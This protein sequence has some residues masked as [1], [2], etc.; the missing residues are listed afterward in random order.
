MSDQK[1]S[2]FQSSRFEFRDITLDVRTGRVQR[3][4]ERLALEPRAYDLLVCLVHHAGEVMSRQ[5]LLDAIWKDVHVAPHSLTQAVLQLRHA[6]NDDTS[7]PQFIETVHRRGYRFVAP[8]RPPDSIRDSPDRPSV[9]PA[10]IVSLIG[11]DGLLAELTAHLKQTRLLTLTGPG[12]VGKTQLALELARR[13]EM[14]FRASVMV[15]LAIVDDAAKVEREI[16]LAMGA[17]DAGPGD[18]LMRAA[19]AVQ[20]RHLV[21]LLDN[22]EQVIDGCR[23]IATGLL[24]ACPALHVVATTQIPLAVRG[25]TVVRVPPLPVPEAIPAGVPRIPVDLAMIASVALFVQAARSVESSFT[26]T[27]GNAAAICEICRRLEGLPL[28]IELA[29]SVA[30]VLTPQQIAE[31]LDD[32]WRVLARRHATS[33][34]RHETLAA[35]LEWSVALL[36][37]DEQ[38][39]LVRLGVFNGGWTLEAA[40]AVGG[41]LTPG[42][43]VLEGL[44]NLVEKSLVVADTR[45]VRARYRLLE[46]VRLYAQA[47]LDGT[48][49]ADS[50]RHRHLSHYERLVREAAPQMLGSQQVPAIAAIELEIGNIREALDWGLAEPDGVEQAVSLAT[51]MQPYW[52][53][54]GLLSEGREWLERAVDV[55]RGHS[56][57]TLAPTVCALGVFSHQVTDFSTARG[58]LV[59]GLSCLPTDDLVRRSFTLGFLSF[60]YAMTGEFDA[61]DRISAEALA[62]AEQLYD[63]YLAGV[64]LLGRGIARAM[65]GLA[66]DAAATLEEALRRIERS[67]ERFMISYVS[68]NLGL[69]LYLAGR[70]EDAEAA[71]VQSLRVSREIRNHRAVGGC[72]EGLGYIAAAADARW[73]ARLMGAAQA[74]RDATAAPLFPQWKTAHSRNVAAVEK[75]LGPDLARREWVAGGQTDTDELVADILLYQS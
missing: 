32:P 74:A 5:A 39:L 30:G 31:R 1:P 35:T 17:L 4:R 38:A 68:V 63:D 22:C 3:G 27:S 48:I 29:A 56:P 14:D 71:F 34:P 41:D 58:F 62:L 50:V 10:R 59:G 21:L 9:F 73:A 6:L 16:A 40:S 55:T 2:A 23:R 61:A 67:G 64:A 33:P 28:A 53:F 75:R 49:G 19:A 26:L 66:G 44:H 65:G 8:V 70:L 51:A 24:D 15:D 42:R 18:F 52:L 60:N 45:G 36:T 11:R 25:E 37:A 72:L 54:R 20:S 46:T 47:R 13:V 12:G 43:S 57:E 7:R 69:Q